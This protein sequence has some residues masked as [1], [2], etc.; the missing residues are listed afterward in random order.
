MRARNLG[1]IA[2]PLSVQVVCAAEPA[3]YD[4]VDDPQTE[5]AGPG[6]PVERRPTCREGKVALSGGIGVLE[7]IP[8]DPTT[9][10]TLR[11]STVQA[12]PQ[13]GTQQQWASH[14]EF[15]APVDQ[16]VTGF[17]ICADPPG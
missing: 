9:Q 5:V 11:E 2:Q 4:V 8:R 7:E 17:A 6:Q 1:A 15:S 12:D 14:L 16:V 3:G 13:G 10:T